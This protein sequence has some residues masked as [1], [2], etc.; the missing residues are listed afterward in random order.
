MVIACS[1][2][3]TESERRPRWRKNLAILPIRKVPDPILRKKGVRIPIDQIGSKSIQRLSDDMI[4][5]LRD[6]KGVGLAAPQVGESLR[7]VVIEL[8]M[9]EMGNEGDDPLVLINPEIQKCIGLREVEE[10]C[11]SVPG[12]KGTIER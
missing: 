12:Y 4:E 6:A 3:Y 2:S 11:L 5:T 8:A 1:L 9:T 7:L 10:G